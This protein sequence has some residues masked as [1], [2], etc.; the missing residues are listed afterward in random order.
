MSLVKKLYFLGKMAR[1]FT[2]CDKTCKAKVSVLKNMEL[3]K[4]IMFA[5]ENQIK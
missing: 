1:D 4:D 3:F 2:F 5:A